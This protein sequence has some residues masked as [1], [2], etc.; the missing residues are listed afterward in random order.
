MET[1]KPKLHFEEI[2][3]IAHNELIYLDTCKI[4]LI[5]STGKV[6]GLLAVAMDITAG[7]RDKEKMERQLFEMNILLT[8]LQNRLK[9]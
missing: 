6:Y 1:R 3:H 2:E 4:P 5:D 9:Q 7:K 8:E